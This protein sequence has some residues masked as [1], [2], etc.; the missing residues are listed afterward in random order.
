M[1]DGASAK[2]QPCLS[3]N[4]SFYLAFLSFICGKYPMSTTLGPKFIL[5]KRLT[6]FIRGQGLN[7]YLNPRSRNR[8]P[9]PLRCKGETSRLMAGKTTSLSTPLRFK[10][11]MMRTVTLRLTLRDRFY[12]H[13]TSTIKD[14]LSIQPT[15]DTLDSLILVATDLDIEFVSDKPRRTRGENALASLERGRTDPIRSVP[16]TPPAAESTAWK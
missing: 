5:G 13:L 9:P 10:E 11:Y 8:G 7:N 14:D 16:F 12:D 15:K 4:L 2:L 3:V 1:F 6:F